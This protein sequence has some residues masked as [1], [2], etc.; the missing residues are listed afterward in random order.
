MILEALILGAG[1]AIQQYIQ[2][3]QAQQHAAIVAKNWLVDQ[4]VDEKIRESRR[5]KW[6]D[7]R[8]ECAN[9][10]CAGRPCGYTNCPYSDRDQCKYVEDAIR[11]AGLNKKPIYS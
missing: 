1:A 8:R 11:A 2:S 3:G 6:L 7:E 5:E 4:K 10:T 9:R